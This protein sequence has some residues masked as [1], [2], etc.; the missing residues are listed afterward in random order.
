MLEAKTELQGRKDNQFQ[1]LQREE[2]W[3]DCYIKFDKMLY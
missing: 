2:N 1:I 3:Q